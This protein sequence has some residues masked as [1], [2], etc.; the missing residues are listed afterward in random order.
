MKIFRPLIKTLKLLLKI[1][2]MYFGA[3][4]LLV[5]YNYLITERYKFP[6][7]QPFSG[8]QW[9]NPYEHMDSS[10]WK[11]TNLHMH[12]RAWGGLTNGSDNS[13]QKVW[14]TYHK[15]GYESVGISNYQSIDTYN[16]D[17]PFYIPV[18]EHGYGIFKNHQLMIGANKVSWF[19]LP[20]GQNLHHKQYILNGLRPYTEMISINHPAFFGGYKP[21]DFKYLGNYDL[22]EALNGYRNS[23]AHW[24]SALSAGKPAFLMADDDMHDISNPREASRRLIVVN[25]PDNHRKS[26]LRS[27]YEGNSYGVE[28]RIPADES[29]ESKA[30]RFNNLPKLQFLTVSN[31][32]LRVQ[33]S[34]SALEIRFFGQGGKLLAKR[35]HNNKAQYVMKPEDTYVRT[36]V[37]YPAAHD[38]EGVTF[39]LNPVMRTTDGARP[40]MSLAT[41]DATATWIYR[42]LMLLAFLVLVSGYYFFSRKR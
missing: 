4:L 10:N 38:P 37:L 36:V 28:I 24:D 40:I 22:I 17:K 26:I 13:S 35:S 19:D 15:L 25:A 32:T 23:I 18:Y 34:S 42:I 30:A 5:F 20:F 1:V 12:S 31:D 2:G 33:M 7:P 29:Y 41:Y 21:E 8:S 6:E 27:L 14:E 16:E 39:F 11:R 9:Y 3:L